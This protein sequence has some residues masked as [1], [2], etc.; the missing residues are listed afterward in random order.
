M[1]FRIDG[2]C[3]LLVGVDDLGWLPLPIVV[4]AFDL[5][6]LVDQ[7]SAPLVVACGVGGGMCGPVVVLLFG[8][9]HLLIPR[10]VGYLVDAFDQRVLFAACDARPKACASV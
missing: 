7:L 8:L 10:H 4:P 3:P 2:P 6:A 5:T 9:L 1:Q